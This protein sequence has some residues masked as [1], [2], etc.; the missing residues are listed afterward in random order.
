MAIGDLKALIVTKDPRTG[1]GPFN[2]HL[3]SN[4][5]LDRLVYAAQAAMDPAERV[6]L[7]GEAM[8][9]GMEDAA[10]IP[11]VQTM[12]SVAVRKGFVRYHSVPI[13]WAWAML[14]EPL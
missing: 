13:G 12:G 8:R 3:Y 14:A 4:A 7:T 11:L 5:E 2:R 9:V 6:R 10:L 1:D